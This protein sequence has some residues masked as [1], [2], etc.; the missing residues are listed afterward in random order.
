[1]LMVYS[2]TSYKTLMKAYIGERKRLDP[3]FSHSSLAAEIQVQK[4]YLSRVLN[5]DADLS[6][7]QVY[8]FAMAVNLA[9]A[10][11]DYLMLLHEIGRCG[12]ELRLRDLVAKRDQMREKGLS[13][14][15]YLGR[16]AEKPSDEA[17]L[18]YYGDPLNPV[19]HMFMTIPKFLANPGLL[20]QEIGI[21]PARILE[22]LQL[23][24]RCGVLVSEKKKYRLAKINLHLDPTSP[25]YRNFA[26]QF[27]LK[28]IHY[29]QHE[30]HD[31]DYFF[32]ASFSAN[33][34]LRLEIRKRF[35]EFVKWIS[36]EVATQNATGVYHLNFDL[37]K[38]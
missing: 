10:E 4:S 36:Q 38:I 21:A 27:R 26:A 12:I 3:N 11:R 23:L 30:R 8:L 15:R 34:E 5:D 1:M 7:D 18:E 9:G 2:F 29:I 28:S 25:L 37:F 6:A 33:E 22:A 17:F 20:E 16:L 35:L 19:V 14:E 31:S 32:T 13:S 24:E